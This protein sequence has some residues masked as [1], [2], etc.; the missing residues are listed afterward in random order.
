MFDQPS[1]LL[2]QR[3]VPRSLSRWSTKSKSISCINYATSHYYLTFLTER[4]STLTAEEIQQDLENIRAAWQWAAKTDRLA[5]LQPS[6]DALA[7]F[8][9]LAN[10]RM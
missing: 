8:P 4:A 1:C 9:E 5:E 3:I 7:R 6:L 10:L 2:L